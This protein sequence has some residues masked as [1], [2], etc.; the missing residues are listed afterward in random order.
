MFGGSRALNQN[1]NV[2][3][4]NVIVENGCHPNSCFIDEVMTQ[5]YPDSFV[6]TNDT[7]LRKY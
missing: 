1:P 4:L 3:A 2:R 6:I 5:R 7:I